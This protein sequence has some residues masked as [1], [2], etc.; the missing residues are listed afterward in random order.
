MLAGRT[1]P[2]KTNLSLLGITAET[3][4]SWH[5]HVSDI[6]K[7][8]SQKLGI[9]FRTKHLY[10]PEQLLILYKA[11]I[12][13]TVEYCSHIWSAAPKNTLKM[14]DSIQKRAVRL[15]N[16]SELTSNFDSLE[17]PRNRR[18]FISF[19]Q[20]FSWK[21]FPRNITD[22]STTCDSCR[23]H[24]TDSEISLICSRPRDS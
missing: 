13:P 8:A 21:L 14:M 24:K 5:T 15:I 19:L 16:D 11:Q 18:R 22:R 23:T 7:R 2:L 6:A 1:I 9:L 12:R 4:M 10:S 3:N 20:I 17:R